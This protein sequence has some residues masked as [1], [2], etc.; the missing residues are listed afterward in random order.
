MRVFAFIALVAVSATCG[1]DP[2]AK[3]PGSARGVG[4]QSN[5]GGTTESGGTI[6]DNGGSVGR[7]GIVGSGGSAVGDGGRVGTGGRAGSGGA[8]GGGRDAGSSR[9][10]A[11]GGS[12][13]GGAGGEGGRGVGSG[14]RLGSGGG[15]GG[16]ERGDAAV[17]ARD[18][19]TTGPEVS[20]SCMSEIVANDYACGSAPP[21][22][23]CKDNSTSKAAECEAVV[24][25]IAATNPCSGNCETECF[26]KNGGN[27]PV[28]A[29]VTALK[30]AACSGGGCGTT[31]AP[32]G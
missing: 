1:P 21:C 5:E 10:T 25:C 14:G 26:N 30:T 29:C 19:A 2:N 11:A 13:E 6:A 20:G 8:A 28:Q 32:R 27:G 9:D 23:A 16:G 12:S 22:S 15:L 31:V 24:K 3:L 4:G 17:A 7:G 18:T